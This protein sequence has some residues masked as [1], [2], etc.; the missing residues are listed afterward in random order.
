M[1][2]HTVTHMYAHTQSHTYTHTTMF[3]P[4]L[5]PSYPTY[6]EVILEALNLW[7]H[8]PAVTT[9]VLKLMAELVLNRAQVQPVL[10]LWG[11]AWLPN[12]RTVH[13]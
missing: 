10:Y 6:T 8:D 7:Y 3:T 4:E 2:T 5:H 11:C 1:H 9:P 12:V 13:V